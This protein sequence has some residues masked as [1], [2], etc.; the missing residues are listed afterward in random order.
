[1]LLYVHYCMLNESLMWKHWTSEFDEM[2]VGKIR[3]L[4]GILFLVHLSLAPSS[5]TH[6]F[7]FVSIKQ[8]YT[9][10]VLQIKSSRFICTAVDTTRDHFRILVVRTWT[11]YLGSWKWEAIKCKTKKKEK[12]GNNIQKLCSTPLRIEHAHVDPSIHLVRWNVLCFSLCTIFCRLHKLIWRRR[13]SENIHRSET[14]K[15]NLRT[16][17]LIINT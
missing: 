15:P 14:I 6:T 16:F 9:I 10:F 2:F 17:S 5:T 7:S 1:M 13:N 11:T 8:I 4:C 3:F 12:K